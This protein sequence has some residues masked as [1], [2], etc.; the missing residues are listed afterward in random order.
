MVILNRI[1][2]IL[3]LLAAI[4]A[5]VFSYLLF[6]KREKLVD[7]WAQMATAISNTAKT[8]DD[9]GT[10]GTSAARDLT[11]EKLKHTNYEQL[12]QALPKLKENVSK[13]VAQRNELADTMQT[14]AARLSI[15]G[16]DAKNLKNIA[17]Y[18]DQE[19]I[20]TNGVQ[21][22]RSNRDTI[23]KEYAQT[24]NKFGANISPNDLNDPRKFRSAINSGNIKVTEAI[25]RRNTY[26]S[27]LSRITQAIGVPAPKVSGPAYNAEL[28]RALR[29]VQAKNSE[30]RTVKSQLAAEKRRT[31]QLSQQIAG[32]RKTIAL[33]NESIQKKDKEI[34]NLTNILNKDGSIELPKKL[35]TSK[36]PECYKYVKGVIEYIDKDYGFVTVNIGKHYTFVQHYGIKQNRVLFPL[37][38]GKEMTVARNA[39]S[40]NPLFIG[41]IRVTK[42]EENSSICNV[43]SGK[44]E[45]VQEGDMVFFSD[46]DIEKALS[47]NKN[48]AGK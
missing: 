21:Q 30:L 7:G 47:G 6:S 31:E 35:L 32:H 10:S 19:R 34:K 36:D 20:F 12:G 38:P 22:F 13:I 46:E 16:I 37:E 2:N 48:A 33:R 8:L 28:N 39:D 44:P 14:S 45:L 9:G 11:E 1:I 23:S 26:A 18:K 42:V 17:S 5:V 40:S 41:K 15:Q 27:Y 3:I 43:I 4:A 29:G 24:L 25:D